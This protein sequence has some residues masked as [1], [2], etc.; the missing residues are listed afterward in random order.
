MCILLEYK[1]P[2][3]LHLILIL[4]ESMCW[5]IKSVLMLLD[6]RFFHHIFHFCGSSTITSVIFFTV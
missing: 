6:V 2:L 3:I 4:A 5:D 1:F